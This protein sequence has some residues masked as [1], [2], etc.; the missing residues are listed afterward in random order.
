MHPWAEEGAHLMRM[1]WGVLQ[2]RGATS[3]GRHQPL[4]ERSGAAD[5]FAGTP[6]A[7][8]FPNPT[9]A[10]RRNSISGGFYLSPQMHSNMLQTR[11]HIGRLSNV[12]DD[13]F[14]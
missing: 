14:P 10:S 7:T 8:R 2:A 5:G 4:R 9:A 12:I 1:G 13:D 3:A 6:G 11:V